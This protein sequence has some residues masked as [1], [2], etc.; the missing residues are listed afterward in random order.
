MWLGVDRRYSEWDSAKTLPE[1]KNI[2]RDGTRV[3]DMKVH[4]S[5]VLK[6]TPELKTSPTVEG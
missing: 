5:G 2:L 3:N 6:K 4:I 1:K